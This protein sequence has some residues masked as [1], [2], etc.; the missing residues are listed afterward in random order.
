[1]NQVKQVIVCRKDLKMRK[2]KL[3]AQVAH[4]SMRFLLEDAEWSD[5]SK[6]LGVQWSGHTMTTPTLTDAQRQWAEGDFTKVVAYVTSKEELDKLI[7]E[8]QDIGLCVWPIIDLGHTEFH[9][10]PTLTC[11][12]FGPDDVDKVDKVTG[13][14]PLL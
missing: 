7:A 6:D 10:V 9:G 5:L 3:A 8:A 1:M 12:A 14:L 11:A 4:A 2:G 13:G